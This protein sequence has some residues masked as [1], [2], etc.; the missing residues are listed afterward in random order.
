MKKLVML[1]SALLAL[2]LLFAGCTP[3]D[4]NTATENGLTCYIS[5]SGGRAF[6]ACWDWDGDPDNTDIVIPERCA[7]AE[8]VSIGGFFGTGVPTP[9][10]V[11]QE[12]GNA[13][14]DTDAEPETVIFTVRFGANI[15]AI[16]R[17][18]QMYG[19]VLQQDGR[20]VSVSARYYFV[21]E[22]E[23]DKFYTEDGHV[24]KKEDGSLVTDIAY[25]DDAGE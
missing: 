7:G 6:A 9:F 15:R 23:N 25:W 1:A 10:S 8:I 12:S 22:G 21:C 17:V 11:R 3:Y 18:G 19:L 20:D 24:Y 2:L 13:R 14:P 16:T 4:G 5:R